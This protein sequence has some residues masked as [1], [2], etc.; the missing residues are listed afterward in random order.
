LLDR[1]QA[2]FGVGKIYKAEKMSIVTW[3]EYLKNWE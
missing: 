2:Y 3:W 1:I